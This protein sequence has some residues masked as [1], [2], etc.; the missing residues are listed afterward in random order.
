MAQPVIH[1]SFA[2]GEISKNLWARVDLDKY[3][4]G[5]ALLENFFVDYRGG[6]SSRMGTEFIAACKPGTV[7][8]RLFPFQF[9]TVATYVLEWGDFYVRIYSNGVPIAGTFELVTPYPES[10]VDGLKYAQSA[11]TMTLTHPDYPVYL[12]KR[13]APTTFTLTAMVVG[14]VQAA[15]G[16]ITAYPASSGTGTSSGYL[17]TATSPDGKEESLPSKICYVLSDNSD[18]AHPIGLHW[19]PPAGPAPSKYTIYKYGPLS[20]HGTATTIERTSFGFIGTSIAPQFVDNGITADFTR[21]PPEFTD[22]I[23][24]GQ[25][26]GTSITAAGSGYNNSTAGHPTV[27]FS[28]GS[29][30]HA[31]IGSAG[32]VGGLVIDYY[33][34]GNTVVPTI[35]ISGS[36]TAVVTGITPIDGTYPSCCTFFQQRLALAASTNSPQTLWLSQTGQV[37]N[38]NQSAITQPT[39]AITIS[40]ASRQVNQIK[41][42]IPM[43]SGMVMLTSGGAWLLSGG[44]A[45]LA[46][47]PTDVSAQPQASSG[48]NDMPP[49]VVNNDILYVQ[50][51]GAIVRDLVFNFYVS[52]YFGTDRSALANHLFYGYQLKEWCFAE[53]PFRTVWA[54]RNDGAALCM[55]FVPEQ[56]VYAW[57]HHYTKGQFLSTC[58]VV[59]GQEDAVYFIVRRS[60]GGSFV[61]YIERLHT[62]NFQS[63]VEFAFCLDAGLSLA[64]ERPA[65]NLT[66][67]AATGNI[68]ITADAAVFGSGDVGKVLRGFY[69]GKAN[70][71]GYTSTTV[72][73]ATVVP[74]GLGNNFFPLV[75][76]STVPAMLTSGNWMMATPVTTLSG[77]S[78]L[79][80]QTV[81]ALADGQVIDGLVVSGG[82]VT[83]PQ[84]ASYVTVGLNFQCKLQTLYLDTGDPTIQG[85]RKLLPA[86]TARVQDARGLFVGPTDDKGNFDPTLMLEYKDPALA[87]NYSVPAPLFTGDLFSSL[88][89]NWDTQ[90]D[91]CVLQKYPLPATILGLIP[92]V[93]IG[94]T[95]R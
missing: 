26:T 60:I 74:D 88:Y 67:S 76:F 37:Y 38:F 18:L 41:S 63:N 16:T 12:L 68:T 6:A 27:T 4:V 84:A 13:T 8:P 72:V 19:V 11:D 32:D 17:V 25:I 91:V 69:G 94:D 58:S 50:S 66:L 40:L 80:G 95:G 59:E 56:E 70:I 31:A 14:P 53:E 46:I 90:G 64:Q 2:A 42:M 83:L 93:V 89:W 73:S 39:D 77:L 43:P 49:I 28:D 45:Q 65:A 22:P 35:T 15:P 55:T 24:P 79:E 44:G 52:S 47:T 10:A 87:F 82:A 75:M 71:T 54:T 81:Q 7:E 48:A 20:P 61:N 51:R 78:H 92:Q 62:R 85:K 36:A 3:H 5:A 86:L 29:L 1:T 57:S 23:S 9:S 34:H 33:A 30:G 21:Q